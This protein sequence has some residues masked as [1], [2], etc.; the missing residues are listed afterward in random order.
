MSL[1]E[2]TFSRNVTTRTWDTVRKVGAGLQE[3]A[4]PAAS[5]G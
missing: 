3:T 2:K 4:S 5:R 1:I